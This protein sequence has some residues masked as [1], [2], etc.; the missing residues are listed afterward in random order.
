MPVSM[1]NRLLRDESTLNEILFWIFEK[2]DHIEAVIGDYL[3]RHNVINSGIQLEKALIV[4][5]NLGTELQ[6]VLNKA[7]EKFPGKS[8]KIRSSKEFYSHPEFQDRLHYFNVL[9]ERNKTFG[10]DI[11]FLVQQF[12]NRQGHIDATPDQ[13]EHCNSYLF[14]ELVI[15]ELLAEEGHLINIYPGKQLLVLK[16][17]VSGKLSKI[18]HSLKQICLVEM[19]FKYTSN[20]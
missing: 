20:K 14:E 12:L 10:K 3:H 2:T 18:S 16:D 1:N 7:M 9:H 8:L 11:D 4:C 19:K 6:D 5:E 17:I 15:F 13:I